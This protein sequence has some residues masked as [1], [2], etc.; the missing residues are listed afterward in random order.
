MTREQLEKEL[1]KAKIKFDASA[2]DDELRKKVQAHR[3]AHPSTMKKMK[4]F[5]KKTG[6][7]MGIALKVAGAI[8]TK[9]PHEQEHVCENENGPCRICEN[10]N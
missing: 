10:V 7:K 2:S 9:I 3:D 6:K 8:V 4:K 5:M 1:N